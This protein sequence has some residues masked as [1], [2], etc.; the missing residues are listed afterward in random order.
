MRA[1]LLL[2]GCILL[3]PSRVEAQ[4]EDPWFG[5]DKLLHFSASAALAMGGYGLGLALFDCEEPRL[6]LGG[7]IAL[8]AGIAKELYDLGGAGH[9][10]FRDL[11]WDVLGTAVG[12]LL[13]W[14]FDYLFL[15]RGCDEEP[16]PA[17]PGSSLLGVPVSLNP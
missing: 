13:S 12:L 5:Q 17:P 11:A 3:L 15:P 2:V 8:G 7:G 6:L 16:A 1:A 14:A 10:S 4:A 9:A